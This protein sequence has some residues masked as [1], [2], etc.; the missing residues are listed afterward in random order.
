MMFCFIGSWQP[1][2]TLREHLSGTGHDRQYRSRQSL[3]SDP[4]TQPT[5]RASNNSRVRPPSARSAV[6]GA[7]QQLRS[8]KP[9]SGETVAVALSGGLD[10]MVTAML[11]HERGYPV[12]AVHMILRPDDPPEPGKHIEQLV[13]RL[14]ISLHVVDLRRPFLQNVI[15]PFLGAYR[16]GKTPNPCVVCNPRIK[17]TFLP[18]Q[19]LKIGA[20][21]LAT[22]HY[23]RLLVDEFDSRLRLFR[24]LDRKKDQSY[25]LYGV[26]QE[27]LSR[28]FFPL[29]DL[30][31]SQVKQL[32][33][34]AGLSEYHQPE[35]QE[36][37]FIPDQ[38]YRGFL[39]QHLGTNLPEPGPILD[40]EGHQLGEHGGIHRYTIG[41][42]RGIGIP[43]SAPYYVVALDPD[44]NSVRVGRE[45]DLNRSEMLVTDVSW[46][47]IPPPTSGLQARVKVRSR[48][49]E[50]P[51]V[52]EPVSQGILVRFHEP[53][54]AIT[55]GQSAVF[56]RDE[57]V[58]GGGIIQRV[59]S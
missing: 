17:F 39:E 10:S 5:L 3:M 36:I 14:G 50:A 6:R 44:T 33:A 19:A 29:G 21:M 54:M 18:E 8:H 47:A 40:L 9:E 20:S 53:Q 49:R 24:G 27:Q 12:K 13:A 2:R 32:A 1:L 4:K 43:S 56:Y 48:H 57:E 28:T 59:I 42:R 30:L 46:I 45:S 58:L 22:G 51:A 11:L 38:D 37:C 35:S 16:K 26:S 7:A 52:L 55:P 41:Q 15:K 31:K 23:A 25:F 34:T